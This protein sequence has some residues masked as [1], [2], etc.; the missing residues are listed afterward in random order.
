MVQCKTNFDAIPQKNYNRIVKKVI[1]LQNLRPLILTN[2]NYFYGK[3][4]N[5]K[6]LNSQQQ[7]KIPKEHKN[8]RY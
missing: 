7:Q 2:V 3:S 6:I 4:G 5:R 8:G 1:P